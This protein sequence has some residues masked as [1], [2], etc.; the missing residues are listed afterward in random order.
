MTSPVLAAGT[1]T[2]AVQVWTLVVAGLAVVATIVAAVLLRRTGKGTVEAA[3][4]AAVA[5][6]RSAQ[7]AERSA[8]AAQ[9]SVG[10]NR[11]TAAGVAQRAHADALSKRYQD[12]ATQLGNESAAVRLAGVYAMATLADDWREQRQM[13]VDVLC[14]FLRL[15]HKEGGATASS[16]IRAVVI[17]IIGKHLEADADVSWSEMKLDLTRA[18][19]PGGHWASPVFNAETKFAGARVDG[20]FSMVSAVF[21]N[22]PDFSNV[23]VGPKGEFILGE[24]ALN[25]SMLMGFKVESGGLVNIFAGSIHESAHLHIT[26]TKV[27]GVF[28]LYLS[29]QE[30][31]PGEVDFTITEV[32]EGGRLLISIHPADVQ[33]DAARLPEVTL[34]WPEFEDGARISVDRRLVEG[35]RFWI[36]RRAS[37]HFDELASRLDTDITVRHMDS[38]PRPNTFLMYPWTAKGPK[39]GDELRV[40]LQEL[41]E[42]GA[43]AGITDPPVPMTDAG[44]ADGN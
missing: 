4:Q 26:P 28:C 2:S 5:S 27:A 17:D 6:E 35:S 13:C 30:D 38:G 36:K 9:A 8:E 42:R 16:E 7:A 10:V 18:H 20:H 23:T 15:G 34:I 39:L 21:N 19:I 43:A 41:Y 44:S 29:E 31:A 25:D 12:A 11:E 24:F 32:K 14:A 40:E 1:V 33:V 22:A 37:Q 3:K